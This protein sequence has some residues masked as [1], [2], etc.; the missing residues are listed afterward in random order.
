MK[1]GEF[2]LSIIRECTFKL[3]GGAMFGVVPKTLWNKVTNADQ[4]NRILLA[5]N[6]LLIETEHG[7]VLIETGMGSRWSDKE[8]E[9]YALTP[10][11]EPDNVLKELGLSNDQ[12]QAVVISHMHF[13]HIGGAVR[14][15]N[16]ELVPTFPNAKYFVQRG[17]WEFAQSANAR[18][19]ASYRRDDWE[20]LAKTGCLTLIDGD[21]EILPGV[22]VAV[23]GGHTAHHQVVKFNSGK[24]KG[25]YFADIIPTISHL[26]PPWVMGYDHFPLASCDIKAKWLAQAAH[27]QWLVVFD[28]EIEVPWGRV[29]VAADQKFEFE[30]LAR[31]TLQPRSPISF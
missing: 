23:T 11:V 29:K 4:L 2:E 10:L 31:E 12:V 8:K 26:S 1:F 27:E 18:A 20:P 21:H 17:E 24:E 6:L 19:R 22:S 30:P 16:G 9:R 28:H 3:D 7:R 14:S 25:V 5:C 13:D 15:L